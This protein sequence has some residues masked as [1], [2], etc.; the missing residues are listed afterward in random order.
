M[1]LVA[2]SAP[3]LRALYRSL[4]LWALCVEAEPVPRRLW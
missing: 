2:G 3:E 4:A 1:A